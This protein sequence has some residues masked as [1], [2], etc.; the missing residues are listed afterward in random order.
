MD[1]DGDE[2]ELGR[3]DVKVREIWEVQK[4]VC[5]LTHIFPVHVA[6]SMS[7]KSVAHVVG[8]ETRREF[9]ASFSRCL[10]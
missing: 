10:T 1:R 6:A 2:S 4:C 8:F 3:V 9:C 7:F 5:I